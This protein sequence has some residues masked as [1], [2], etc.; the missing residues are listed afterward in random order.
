MTAGQGDGPD[1]DPFP[2]GHLPTTSIAALRKRYEHL[3]AQGAGERVGITGR[4]L[5]HR[6][7][8][9]LC[10]ATVW[11][12]SGDIQI[13]LSPDR[14]GVESL[15]SWRSNIDMGDQVA[16]VGEVMTSPQGECA[17]IADR[18]SLTSKCLRPQ[19]D[20]TVLGV[21]VRLRL[22]LGRKARR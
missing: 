9:R 10:S 11:D 15:E 5:P 13:V 8:G 14:L 12:A 7:G 22:I 16:V 17:V 4:V 1:D 20:S 6:T 21:R 2:A 3:A 19:P 18:W